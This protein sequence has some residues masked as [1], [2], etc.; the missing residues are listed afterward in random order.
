[1]LTLFEAVVWVLPTLIILLFARSYK[2]FFSE[3]FYG[4]SFNILSRTQSTTTAHAT[5]H[6]QRNHS[7]MESLFKAVQ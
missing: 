5:C 2:L 6:A 7:R 3:W 1:M 4:K